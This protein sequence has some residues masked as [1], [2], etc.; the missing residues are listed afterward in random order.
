MD[1]LRGKAGGV[2]STCVEV[3]RQDGPGCKKGRTDNQMEVAE[4]SYVCM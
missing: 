2:D 3:D 1:V 4:I